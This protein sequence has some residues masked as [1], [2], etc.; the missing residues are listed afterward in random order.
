MDFLNFASPAIGRYM[1]VWHAAL[2]TQNIPMHILLTIKNGGF[3]R[4]WPGAAD[5]GVN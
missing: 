5:L 2:A 3:L 1:A 4:F